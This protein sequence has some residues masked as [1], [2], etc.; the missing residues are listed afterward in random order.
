[1][2]IGL[3]G[4][5]VLS[6]LIFNP[7]IA[8]GEEQ[9]ISEGKVV[10]FDYTLT[11]DGQVV[12]STQGKEPLEYTHG[13]K[14]IISGLEDELSGMKAGDKKKVVVAAGEAYGQVNQEAILEI[15][16]A[17]L[18]EGLEPKV[19]MVLQMSGPQGQKI[20]GIVREVKDDVLLVDFNH[21]LAGKD[22][23]FDV[24]IVAVK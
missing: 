8:K 17:N 24:E 5:L 9:M 22:L 3:V 7:A 23:T 1:M 10:Q 12:D 20:P 18:G 4:F 19:G 21:P 16:K 14:M 15:P 2:K 13:Q 11:V 6:V